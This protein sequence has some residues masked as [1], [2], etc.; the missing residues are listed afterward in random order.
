MHHI[1]ALLPSS[2]HTNEDGPSTTVKC[3]T[4][5]SSQSWTLRTAKG[6]SGILRTRA[7]KN[8]RLEEECVTPIEA[9]S[10]GEIFERY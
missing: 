4:I 5:V 10:L 3:P 9:H 7:H 8:G 6:I 2:I 1:V